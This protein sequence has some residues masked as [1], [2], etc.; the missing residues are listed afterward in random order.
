MATPPNRAAM[1]ERCSHE[2]T[3]P[4]LF[5]LTFKAGGSAINLVSANTVILSDHE[6]NTAVENQAIDHAHHIGQMSTVNVHKLTS[7][8]TL[9][10]RIHE[11]IATKQQLADDL[12]TEGEGALAQL[13]TDELRDLLALQ[14]DALD[15]LTEEEGYG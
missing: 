7:S 1:I 2:P 6:W 8:G 11:F 3:A 5:L 9:E 10:Q 4:H 15:E 13:T 12:I 14:Q